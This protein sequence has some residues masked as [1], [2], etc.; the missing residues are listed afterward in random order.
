MSFCGKCEITVCHDYPVLSN[1][2]YVV[3]CTLT[4][5]MEIAV[6]I[7]SNFIVLAW[8]VT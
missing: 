3:T 7:T 5:K 4:G 6:H 2:K 8:K 1:H